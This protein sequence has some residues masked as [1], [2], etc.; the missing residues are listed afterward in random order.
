MMDATIPMM[1][2]MNSQYS[3]GVPS[4]KRISLVHNAS[5]QNG[6]WLFTCSYVLTWAGICIYYGGLSSEKWL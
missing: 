3:M 5:E 2:T 6:D 1:T 4:N